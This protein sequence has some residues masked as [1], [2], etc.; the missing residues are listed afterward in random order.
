MG[1]SII[2]LIRRLRGVSVNTL[3][4]NVGIFMML[5]VAVTY[6]M[7]NTGWKEGELKDKVQQATMTM[8]KC[9]DESGEIEKTIWYKEV[10]RFNI[11]GNTIDRVR[12]DLNG[13]LEWKQVSNILTNDNI[14]QALIIRNGDL[15]ATDRNCVYKFDSENR[16]I[17]KSYYRINGGLDCFYRYKYDDRGNNIQV[18]QYDPSGAPIEDA[19]YIYD[20]FGTWSEKK[21]IISAGQSYI[22]KKRSNIIPMGMKK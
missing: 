14:I 3:I 9:S 20:D 21:I 7:T 13:V 22:Q 1:Q 2:T 8:Y 4:L 17:E 10:Y 15:V 5:F 18:I 16:L 12:Y 6:G 19:F 11:C